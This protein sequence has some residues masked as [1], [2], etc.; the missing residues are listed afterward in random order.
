MRSRQRRWKASSPTASTSSISRMS[1]STCAA[2][3][4]PRR[5]SIPLEYRFSGVS[6]NRPSSAK[7]TISSNRRLISLRLI[8]SSEPYRK[9]FSR[10]VSSG[11][12][13]AFSSMSAP[14]RPFVHTCP[15]HGVDTRDASRSDV[16][17]PLPFG[18][19]IPSASPSCTSNVTSASAQ[20]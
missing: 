15:D 17:L 7:S 5:T 16:D 20:M 1:G 11:C 9:M 13:P 6:M 2:T 3:L 12:R 18:P 4:N 19:M 8:P 10:P 14:T